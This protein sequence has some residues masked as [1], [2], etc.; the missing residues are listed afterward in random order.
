MKEDLNIS[1]KLSSQQI[2]EQL[3]N[4]NLLIGNPKEIIKKVNTFYHVPDNELSEINN[5]YVDIIGHFDYTMN[6]QTLLGSSKIEV[7]EKDLD[8]LLDELINDSNVD[9][10]NLIKFDE[11]HT[12]IFELETPIKLELIEKYQ[13]TDYTEEEILKHINSD[14]K[15]SGNILQKTVKVFELYESSRL[16]FKDDA[17][18]LS[19][20]IINKLITFIDIIIN[21]DG[22][23]E[24]SDTFLKYTFDELCKYMSPKDIMERVDIVNIEDS[25][26]IKIIKTH[27]PNSYN[28][29]IFLTLSS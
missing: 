17:K 16:Y 24:M 19:N 15:K 20:V 6:N 5:E 29:L 9:D 12:S 23:L 2:F 28:N 11:T 1:S 7:S 21:F 25:D 8:T 3:K 26:Y 10:I 18:D 27:I 14:H 13:E 4:E 22:I